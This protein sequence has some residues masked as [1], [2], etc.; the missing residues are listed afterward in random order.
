M[1]DILSEE[2]IAEYE[3]RLGDKY[4]D[5]HIFTLLEDNLLGC[6]MHF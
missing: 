6:D 4:V 1:L 2:C 5:D 3:P